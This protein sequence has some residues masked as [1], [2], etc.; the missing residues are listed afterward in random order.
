MPDSPQARFTMLYEKHYDEVLAFCTRRIGR[1]EADDA[2]ADVFAVAWRRIDESSGSQSV[3]GCMASPVVCW[4][5]G[6]RQKRLFGRVSGL[7]LV[8]GELPDV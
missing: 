3:R 2:T 7:A 6:R 4:R 8:P 5:T 1:T